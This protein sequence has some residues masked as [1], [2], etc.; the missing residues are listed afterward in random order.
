MENTWLPIWW[1]Q[2]MFPFFQPC[3]KPFEK[4]DLKDLGQLQHLHGSI[5]WRISTSIIHT[6]AFSQALNVFEIFSF[7]I[8][9]KVY[10]SRGGAL[11]WRILNFISD[12]SRNVWSIS[13]CI[14]YIHK[15]RKMLQ[16]VSWKWRS[17]SRSRKRGLETFWTR[18]VRIHIGYF[19]QNFYLGTYVYAKRYTHTHTLIYMN[20][21]RETGMM[22]LGKI[23][24][25]DLP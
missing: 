23:C 21:Q 6:W 9:C 5:R 25:A 13:H 22:T 12:G 24:K 19:F 20:T 15:S 1:Q 14:R 18:N 17:G 16:I 2:Q 3:Q 7:Q 10:N 4:F 11:R 8:V